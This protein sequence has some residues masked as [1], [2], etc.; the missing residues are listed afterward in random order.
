[1]KIKILFIA[2]FL[3]SKTIVVYC[4]SILPEKGVFSDFEVSLTE[5]KLDKDAEA[6]IL[7][8]E[9]FSDHDEDYH[10]VTKRRIRIKILTEKG[11]NWGTVT[12]PF[13][14]KDEFENIIDIEG[15]T[16]NFN[17]NG[18]TQNV[19]SISKKDIYSEKIN[20]RI[21]NIKF[22]LPA[23]KTGSIIEYSYTSIMKHYG[24]LNDWNFQSEIPTLRS[25]YLLTILP[26]TNFSYF[27]SKRSNYQILILPKPTTGQ[28]YFEMFDIPGLKF[29]AYMNAP[30]D[31]LQR[32]EFQMNSYKDI[33]GITV[34]VNDTWS[35]L[36]QE[37]N[38]SKS[39]GSSI[40]K[41]LP[42]IDQLRIQILNT[43]SESEKLSIIYKYVQE[44]FTWNR[45]DSKYAPD[46]LKKVIE[47]RIG[48]SGEL[49]LLLVNMLQIFKIE[50]YPLL[51][52]E[53]N[54]GKVDPL[55]PLL[56]RFNKTVA[57]AIING[58]AYIL[59]ATESYCPPGLIP[60]SL[61]N[62]FALVI[63]NKTK[64]LIKI[65][66]GNESFSSN[67]KMNSKVDKEGV[68]SGSAV[69]INQ[70]YALQ[71]FGSEL[72]KNE[73][74]FVREIIEKDNQNIEVSNFKSN[75]SSNNSDS[76]IIQFDFK[77]DL[78][79]NTRFILFNYNF[80]TRQNKNPFTNAE[81]FTDINF[82]HPYSINIEHEIELP[83]EIS[84][85]NLPKNKTLESPKKN[86]SI[87]RSIENHGNKLRI[88]INF[89]Q[90]ESLFLVDEY[91][92]LKIFYSEMI[93]MLNE[94]IT[95]KR[96]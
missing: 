1:M 21:S 55:L 76:L 94:T 5:C 58:K 46:G 78:N 81:R 17:E 74:S 25:V 75:Y 32:V 7:L 60:Y 22:A 19:I 65:N 34:K 9:A 88:K 23:V 61:L 90:T 29:E 27:V 41:D 11:L 56:D 52:A 26:N 91:S 67:I 73:K 87:S 83:T 31:Y 16:Y 43:F 50:A 4:Q 45:V 18:Q 2:G 77:K 57:Y 8:D 3:I 54:Y 37:L 93:L 12:I 89:S 42:G 48:S 68:F 28:V 95:L 69:I 24:G 6:V 49:N 66:S 47:K 14:S 53:R 33:H 86:I 51:V 85:E 35:K 40:K 70:Q 44:N 36:A 92:N 71:Y 13:Y 38:E 72:K 59:D 20:D 79:D 15:T 39:L 82:G 62:T 84:I 63:N 80:F 10:L 64:D 30:K 96:L